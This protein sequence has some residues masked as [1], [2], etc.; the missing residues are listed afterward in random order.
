MSHVI[1][2]WRVLGASWYGHHSGLNIKCSEVPWGNE[3]QLGEG[4]ISGL[5]SSHNRKNDFLP[6][7][8][9][10][11][12]I[13]SGYKSRLSSLSILDLLS[14]C[15]FYYFPIFPVSLQPTTLAAA[16][17]IWLQAYFWT[18][19]WAVD[20]SRVRHGF[21]ISSLPPKKP[22]RTSLPLLCF[23]VLGMEFR[24]RRHLLNRANWRSL[25]DEDMQH[26]LVSW[27]RPSSVRCAF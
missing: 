15:H 27:R 23:Q 7:D 26:R 13:V 21:V 4:L 5:C 1:L 24:I 20:F 12:A 18:Y 2:Q 19:S 9:C 16:S 25:T 3:R 14:T 11:G 17:S 8:K 6:L 10:H 22:T